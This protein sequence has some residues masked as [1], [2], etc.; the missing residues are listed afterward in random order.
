LCVCWAPSTC[1][2]WLVRTPIYITAESH[3]LP[4]SHIAGLALPLKQKVDDVASDIE[5]FVLKVVASA[6]LEVRVRCIASR[7]TIALTSSHVAQELAFSPWLCVSYPDAFGPWLD[8][9]GRASANNENYCKQIDDLQL[10]VL[11]SS[12]WLPRRSQRRGPAAT[13]RPHI[14]FSTDITAESICMP[15]R[16]TRSFGALR[17]F[18]RALQS[19]RDPHS[20]LYRLEYPR[21]VA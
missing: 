4:I 14:N 17:V 19:R 10:D 20:Q 18:A 2:E 21:K 9:D 16:S 7:E 8:A 11:D 12:K 13:R 15:D 1:R 5:C 3:V 6:G